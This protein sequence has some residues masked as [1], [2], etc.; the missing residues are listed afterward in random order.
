MRVAGA[1]LEGQ[2]KG[3]GLDQPEVMS[4]KA[5]GIARR[6]SQKPEA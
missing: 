1:M 4:L 2:G 6:N 5:E 3:Q